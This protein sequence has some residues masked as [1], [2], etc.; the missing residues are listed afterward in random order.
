MSKDLQS[1]RDSFLAVPAGP[2]RHDCPQPAEV[3]DAAEGDLSPRRLAR[4]VD[5]LASCAACRESWRLA[6]DLQES[7]AEAQAPE[8]VRPTA[9]AWW[10]WAAAAAAAAVLIVALALPRWGT[11]GR[12]ARS[13]APLRGSVTG[14]LKSLVSET[15]PQPR[16]R[17]LLRWSPADRGARYQVHV[18]TRDL[19]EVAGAA[20]LDAPEYGVPERSLAKL[21][22]N[23]TL[24]WQVS[25]S[26][27]DGR[28]ITSPTFLV[29][30]Q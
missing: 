27:P 9:S 14:E 2:P 22:P 4:I 26:L 23:A 29:R 17:L 1:L 28:S 20:G 16:T 30:V 19:T 13:G 5:H 24:L 25:A 12:R 11:L 18:T 8:V 15:D 6:R 10:P 21:P 3:W 7:S